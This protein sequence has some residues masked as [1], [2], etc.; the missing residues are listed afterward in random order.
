L[1][2]IPSNFWCRCWVISGR[3]WIVVGIIFLKSENEKGYLLLKNVDL[4]GNCI[5]VY[6]KWRSSHK[7]SLKQKKLQ[8]GTNEKSKHS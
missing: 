3:V 4:I 7:T 6:E 2:K 8:K 1:L 5:S